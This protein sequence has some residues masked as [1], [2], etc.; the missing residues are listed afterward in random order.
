MTELDIIVRSVEVTNNPVLLETMTCL[1]SST[2]SLDPVKE[3]FSDSIL[4]YVFNEEVDG[5]MAQIETIWQLPMESWGTE[6]QPE[7]LE[8]SIFAEVA[9]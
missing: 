4:D 3:P 6:G 9:E 1:D 8:G 5:L 7:A 2:I